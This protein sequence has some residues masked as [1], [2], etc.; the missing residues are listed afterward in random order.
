MRTPDATRTATVDEDGSERPSP[1]QS[2]ITS[3]TDPEFEKPVRSSGSHWGDGPGFEIVDGDIDGRGYNETSCDVIAVP[4]VGAA[5]IDTWVRDPLGE[6]YFTLPAPVELE[7]YPTV[8]KLP[9]SSVLTPTIDRVLPKASHLWIRQGIRKEV[10]KARVM[11]YRHRELVEGMTIEQAAD[12]LLIEIAKMRDGLKRSRPIFFICHSIGGLIVK[13]ALVKAKK[14]DQLKHLV[15]DCHGITFFATPHRGSSYLSMPH[16]RE[17]IA[18]LLYLERPL[19]SSMTQQL[20]LGHKPLLKLHDKFVDLASEIRIWTFYETVDSQLSG[21]A[22]CDLDQVHFSA[23]ITSIKSGLV[24]TRAEQ[25]LS[26]ESDHAH[27]ASFGPHNLQ[28]MHSYLRDLGI[29]VHKAESLSLKFVHT[30]LQLSSKVRVEIIGFYDDPDGEQEQ[31]VRLYV[32][33]H[34][35]D[36]FLD[37]GP[38]ECLRGRL[39]SKVSAKSGRPLPPSRRAVPSPSRISG[40]LGIF[41]GLGQRILG[42]SSSKNNR[43]SPDRDLPSH[44]SPEIVVTSH[45]PRRPSFTGAASEPLATT[46]AS[47]SP[48]RSRGLTVPALSTPG[49]HQPSSTRRD[50][51]SAGSDSSRSRPSSEPIMP[52]ISPRTMEHTTDES[53]TD[54]EVINDRDPRYAR[55]TRRDRRSLASAMQD[56]TAGFSRPTP[57]RRKFMWI[58]VP[59]NNPH[60]VKGIFEKLS[61][62]QNRSYTKLLS[63]EHWTSKHV[64]GRNANFHLSYVKP[65]CGFL[66]AEANSPRPSSSGGRDR[67]ASPSISPAHFYLYIPYLHYDTYINLLRRRN[68]IKRR[69]EHGRTRPVPKDVAELESLDS[70]VI[71]E[72]IGHDPPLNARRTLDQYGYPSLQDTWARDDDQMLYKLT[73][74]RKTGPFVPKRDMYHAGDDL[75]PTSSPVSRLVSVADTFMNSGGAGRM[76]QTA[77]E[78]EEDIID[79]KALMV[80]QLWLWAVDTTTLLTFFPK[81]ESH[82]TEGP[83]FQQADLRNSIYNELNGD[84][85]GRCDNALDLAAF[86]TLHAVTVLMD[87]TSHPDLEVFRIFE[88]ALGILTER[89]TSSLKRFRMQSYKKIH[90]DS[91]SDDPDEYSAK[92]IKKR[93]Q[94]ELERAERENRENT[95]AVLELRDLEDELRTLGNL[96]SEQQEAI[97]TMKRCYEKAELQGSTG[98]GRAFLVEALKR[99]DEYSKQAHDMLERVDAT[100]KDYEKLQEM[101]QRQGKFRPSIVMYSKLR[102][103]ESVTAQV[104]EVRWQRLQTELASSQNLSVI[105]FTTFTVIFLPLSFFT[106]LF[107]MNTQE[108]GGPDPNNFISLKT[109]GAI[110]LPGSAFLI[111]ITLIAAFSSRVQGVFKL[112]FRALTSTIEHTNKQLLRLEPKASKKA[113]EKRMQVRELREQHIQRKRDR[114]Y[115][116]WETVRAERGSEYQIPDSNRQ[117]AMRRRIARGRGTWGR[118]FDD[119][120]WT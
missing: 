16:L 25:A 112:C 110:S 31:D 64:Q 11:L 54:D 106:S 74:E 99:L 45:M 87:R 14:D 73:K 7:K 33:K 5:P 41:Q 42:S 108:W 38:E 104:D 107:G 89:M 56:L 116:F 72:Y 53:Q 48:I 77:A 58:H 95:S 71:W 37:K 94:R 27:C 9:A 68:L 85:T 24:R 49:F 114:G 120:S 8:K 12:D 15:F 28:I 65:G 115:D 46:S 47:P 44:A 51:T 105:I 117:G 17:S 43:E 13:A 88:E 10:S 29:A 1:Q 109:I 21:L 100:R 20:R 83:L 76:E 98:R 40:A 102:T 92:K 79:G 18:E 62:V 60:W 81:R 101:V 93:H 2:D 67:S 111:A 75:M 39:L 80:D 35:L 103:D 55:K 78:L 4:C 118:M 57:N 52:D 97:G 66:P 82:P 69:L 84:L 3:T 36:E 23:P 113:K 50:S 22:G 30:P 119:H 19:P 32:S 90:E 91:D 96:F 26:I 70:R 59:F 34:R 86:V 6:G 61:E 63:N